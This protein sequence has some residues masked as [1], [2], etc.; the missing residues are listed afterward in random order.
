[1][2]ANRKENSVSDTPDLA[3]DDADLLAWLDGR[4]DRARKAEVE[5]LLADSPEARDLLFELAR[6]PS[7]EFRSRFAIGEAPDGAY[8]DVDYRLEGPFGGLR[9]A[10][11]ASE[12]H[13]DDEDGLPPVYDGQ[14]QVDM[15]LRPGHRR[16]GAPPAALFVAFED[17]PLVP[18]EVEPLV[19]SNGAMRIKAPAR[20]L[21]ERAGRYTLALALDPG[22][23]ERFSG[24]TLGAARRLDPGVRWLAA[25][26]FFTPDA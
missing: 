15:V 14:S 13:G 1:M 26:C 17:G 23:V 20:R 3:V 22:D 9:A 18:A 7:A 25:D 16:A 8:R 10:M 12:G 6:G 19:A 4:L 21:F 2:S 24:M 11:D 5:A